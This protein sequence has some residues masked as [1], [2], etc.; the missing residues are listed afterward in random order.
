MRWKKP[1]MRQKK[2]WV[3]YK[4]RQKKPQTN[5]PFLIIF[6]ERPCQKWGFPDFIHETRKQKHKTH[7]HFKKK[8]KG[9]HESVLHRV[10]LVQPRNLVK[11]ELG[12]LWKHPLTSDAASGKRVCG[13]RSVISPSWV[14]PKEPCPCHTWPRQ[15][16]VPDK[17]QP[18]HYMIGAQIAILTCRNSLCVVWRIKDAWM[19]PF[20]DSCLTH[21]GSR[22]A[23][24]QLY[25]LNQLL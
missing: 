21:K 5:S 17:L 25:H 23:Q 15:C 12:T 6:F 8:R 24:P 13:P 14:T 1:L 10:I 19:N 11:K 4:E 3:L 9:E 18:L 16:N 2:S 20:A 7:T 22:S